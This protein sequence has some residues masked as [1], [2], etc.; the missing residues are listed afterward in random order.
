MGN[1]ILLDTKLVGDIKGTFSPPISEAT[2]G[3]RTKFSACSKIYIRTGRKI[4]VF[5]LLLSETVGMHMS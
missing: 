1:Q 2:G 5:S 3:E 4:T